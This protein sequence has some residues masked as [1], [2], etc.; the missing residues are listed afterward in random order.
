MQLESAFLPSH[1]PPKQA[2]AN[3]FQFIRSWGGLPSWICWGSKKAQKFGWEVYGDNGED[4]QRAWM[5]TK[6]RLENEEEEDD[7]D[8]MDVLL[9]LSVDDNSEFDP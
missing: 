8:L 3:W 7:K 6:E 4:Y 9:K 5:E 2:Q 1:R